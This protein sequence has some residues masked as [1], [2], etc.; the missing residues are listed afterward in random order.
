MTPE[1][2]GEICDRLDETLLGSE[3]NLG[4]LASNIVVVIR[5]KA[6]QRRRIRTG[7]IVEL[8]SFLE[9]LTTPPLRGY[10]EDPKRVE[11]L[12]RDDTEALTMF[13]KAITAPHGGNRTSKK[14]KSD[15]VTLAPRRGNSRGYTLTRLHRKAP[16]LYADVVAGKLTA[17]RAAIRAGL[18]PVKTPLD[19]LRHW[20]RKASQQERDAFLADLH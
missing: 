10:G 8:G 1:L 4:G 14:S 19:Q 5:E 7:E 16:K 18:R 2:A 3:R 15:N 6:W 12:L 13:K 9:L 11:A 20:W 17:H